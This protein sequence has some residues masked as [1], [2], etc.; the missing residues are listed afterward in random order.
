MG[1]TLP[2]LHNSFLPCDLPFSVHEYPNLFLAGLRLAPM[3]WVNFGD[4]KQALSEVLLNR[5]VE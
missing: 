2:T 1:Y 4:V 5:R 3:R